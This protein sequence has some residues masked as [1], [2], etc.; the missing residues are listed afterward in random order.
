VGCAYTAEPQATAAIS[1]RIP[2]N[3]R[4]EYEA[5]II[6]HDFCKNIADL[7]IAATATFDF[8]VSGF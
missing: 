2:I 6:T 3:V 8:T 4:R 5:S 1:P 7:P